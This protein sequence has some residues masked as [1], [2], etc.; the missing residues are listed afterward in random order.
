MKHVPVMFQEALDS[1]VN[2]VDGKYV[3]C[4]FG[5]GGHSRGILS[6]L[7]TKGALASFDLDELAEIEAKKIKNPNFTFHKTNFKNIA[8]HFN[9]NELDGILIDCGVSSPQIDEPKRGFSFMKDGPLDM[10]FGEQLQM[11]CESIVNNYPYEELVR[12]FKEYGEEI[13]SKRIAREIIAKR[14]QDRIVSTK[15]LSSLIENVKKIKTKKNPATK[16]FQALRIEVNQE[17]DNLKICLDNA[18]RLLKKNGK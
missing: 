18:K 9:D 15:Q 4:T 10:R 5:Q 7:S 6:L 12:I 1:L 16:V 13:E 2:D 14:E 3:D 8:D 17:L 11:S